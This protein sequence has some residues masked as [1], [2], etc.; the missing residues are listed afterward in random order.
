MLSGLIWGLIWEVS[1]C[2]LSLE[3][4][5]S[6]SKLCPGAKQK[7][8]LGEV[9]ERG[10]LKRNPGAGLWKEEKQEHSEGNVWRGKESGLCRARERT[11]ESG[12]APPVVQ[13]PQVARGRRRKKEEERRTLWSLG[14]CF[15]GNSH[16]K[17]YTDMK[18]VGK[19]LK[20]RVTFGG[21]LSENWMIWEVS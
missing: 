11:L 5:L 4:I 15:L 14:Y 9:G 1:L 3:D 19:K 7:I 2:E 17:Y 10:S 6:V 16:L 8:S 12:E 20:W 21:T 18:G 13:V